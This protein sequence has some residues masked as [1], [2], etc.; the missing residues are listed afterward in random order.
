MARVL[1]ALRQRCQLAALALLLRHV[2]LRGLVGRRQRRAGFPAGGDIRALELDQTGLHQTVERAAARLGRT[3]EVAQQV[4]PVEALHPAPLL[5]IEHHLLEAVE[6]AA[7][8]REAPFRLR[9]HP[10]STRSMGLRVR[11]PLRMRL[12]GLRRA[13]PLARC[14]LPP[15]SKRKLPA[16]QPKTSKSFSSACS[17]SAWETSSA[18]STSMAT[19]TSPCRRPD[20][21]FTRRSDS[22]MA[23][24]LI[25][26]LR[27]RKL[28]RHSFT[29][30]ERTAV[31]YPS[32]SCTHLRLRP[33]ERCSTPVARRPWRWWSSA[34]RRSGRACRRVRGSPSTFRP[35]RLLGLALRGIGLGLPELARHDPHELVQRDG[36]GEQPDRVQAL[37]P[38][39]VLRCGRE[40]REQHHGHIA[41]RLGQG[42]DALQH[43][44]AIATREHQVQQD[45]IRRRVAH[46][47]QGALAV[48][49]RL[50][51]VALGLQSLGHHLAEL[52][53]VVDAEETG[54]QWTLRSG[55]YR[56]HAGPSLKGKAPEAADF[57]AP[58]WQPPGRSRPRDPGAP[59]APRGQRRPWAGAGR[60]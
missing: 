10:A 46:P 9:T 29:R 24:E 44:E 27:S 26:P 17:R 3:A 25:R 11:T 2:R 37:G 39:L 54:S 16:F 59:P 33:A 38:A 22:R 58:P 53:I 52:A 28:P 23:S 50:H 60:K 51:A 43:R 21:V 56:L 6:R 40:A 45:Q 41:G 13:R 14:S 34:G 47:V 1:E 30:F 35:A 7:P 32:R 12:A 18:E 57:P 20:P 49:L 36:L 8:A 31:G 19:R 42:P 5:G 15:N 4:A 55:G 48:V